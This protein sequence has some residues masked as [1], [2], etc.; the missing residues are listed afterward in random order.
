MSTLHL[1]LSYS[2]Y[3][4]L[5]LFIFIYSLKLTLLH[6]SLPLS[7]ITITYRGEYIAGTT[8]RSVTITGATQSAQMAQFFIN[9]K[10]QVSTIEY[11]Y[12]IYMYI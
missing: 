9:N 11:I 1:F 5:S 2:Q 10:L 8:N 3:P 6:S 4:I 7:I 12:I